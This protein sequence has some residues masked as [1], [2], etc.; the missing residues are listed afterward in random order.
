MVT[1]LVDKSCFISGPE[2]SFPCYHKHAVDP[3]PQPDMSCHIHVL[4]SCNILLNIFSRLI[5]Y[6]SSG[7][8]TS[9]FRLNSTWISHHS[10]S[11]LSKFRLRSDTNLGVQIGILLT[12]QQ[13]ECVLQRSTFSLPQNPRFLSSILRQAYL[14]VLPNPLSNENPTAFCWGEKKNPKWI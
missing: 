5:L 6:P 7:I 10:T 11:F 1:Q 13:Q 3:C 4:Y 8:W 9:G 12:Q 14:W 2:C